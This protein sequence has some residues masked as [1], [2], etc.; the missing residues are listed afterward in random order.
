[1]LIG[2]GDV[3]HHVYWAIAK[4]CDADRMFENK[5]SATP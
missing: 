4:I 3:L 1:L 2:R 5:V